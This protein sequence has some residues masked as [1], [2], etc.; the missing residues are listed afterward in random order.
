[1]LNDT[2]VIPARVFSDDGKIELLFLEQSGAATWKCMVKPGRKMKAG[3]KV[4]VGGDEGVV[5]GI[6]PDGERIV[7][8]FKSRWI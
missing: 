2:R 7:S 3:A 6:L 8:H 1:M 4:I 5:I